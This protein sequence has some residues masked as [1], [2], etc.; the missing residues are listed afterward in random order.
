MVERLYGV[1]HGAQVLVGDVAIDEVVIRPSRQLKEEIASLPEGVSVGL[2]FHPAFFKS[3]SYQCHNIRI[4]Q[5]ANIYFSELIDVC[6]KSKKK[7]IPLED[8][9]TYKKYVRRMFKADQIERELYKE[10]QNENPTE[11]DKE[12]WVDLR[13]KLYK[14]SVERDYTF[15][16]ER[17]DKIIENIS[18]FQPV[19][20]VLGRAHADYVIQ[21][22]QLLSEKGIKVDHYFAEQGPRYP[23]HWDVPERMERTAIFDFDPK[24]SSEVL[25]YRQSV[26]RKFKAIK[27]EKITDGIPDY[28]GTWD[29]RVLPRGLFEIYFEGKGFGRIEDCFGT[30]KFEGFIDDESGAIFFK[31]YNQEEVSFGGASGKIWYSGSFEGNVCS[32]FFENP[33]SGRREFLIWKNPKKS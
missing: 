27:E 23:W 1:E 10:Y 30:A 14:A 11:S 9:R 17:E 24:V 2:E 15:I 31:E 8:I 3:I 16:V 7:V 6:K 25:K 33:D 13:N 12:K 32:G 22:L 26:I 28:Y 5:G 19:A 4:S 29:I 20:V 21:N 18:K